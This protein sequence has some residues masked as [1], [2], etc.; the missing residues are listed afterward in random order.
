MER[1]REILKFNAIIFQVGK[2]RHGEQKGSI[3]QTVLNTS[4]EL[5]LEQYGKWELS[6]PQQGNDWI[7]I[8]LAN[9]ILVYLGYFFL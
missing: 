4:L 2:L 7:I 5:F 3:Q 6:D 9:K 1:S 8:P